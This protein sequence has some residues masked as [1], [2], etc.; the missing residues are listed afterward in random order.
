MLFGDVR[1]ELED[2]N[3]LADAGTAEQAGLAALRVRLE[4]VDDFDAG[5]EHLDAGRLLIERRSFAMD[6]PRFF[7]VDGTAIVDRLAEDVEDAAEGF[8]SDGNF[9]CGAGVDRFHAANHAVRRL[10]RDAAHL[11]FADVVRD[12]NDDVDG[13]LSEL[14]VVDDADG[15][16]DRRQMP[17]VELDV[18]GG[19][20]DLDDFSGPL[21][22][23][24]FSVRN[25]YFAAAAPDT[26]SM[27]SFVIAAWR[28]RL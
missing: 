24:V 27:I 1:D 28:M 23:H 6:R 8:A 18:D 15:V 22:W 9:D 25:R 13:N 17:F 3:R 10:H 19:A 5:L 21:F 7:R 11:V 14:A 2:E 4:E 26:I 20:D 12:F 16:V